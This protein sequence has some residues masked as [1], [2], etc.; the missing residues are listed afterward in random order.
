MGIYSWP[1][2]QM[3]CLSV[4]GGSMSLQWPLLEAHFSPVSQQACTSSLADTTLKHKHQFPDLSCSV[5]PMFQGNYKMIQLEE[6]EGV[7][8][9]ITDSHQWF[10]QKNPTGY[11]RWK[12]KPR[13]ESWFR[14]LEENGNS[15]EQ[16]VFF[17][18]A[19]HSHWQA[20]LKGRTL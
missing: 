17:S 9:T 12:R 10:T 14:W 18:S 8:F 7:E 13:P 5:Q 15:K 1:Y 19:S 2:Q 3:E 4:V 16:A 11:L 6:E 20:G